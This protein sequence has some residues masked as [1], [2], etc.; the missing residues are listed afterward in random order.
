MDTR[1]QAI[2]YTKPGCKLCEE[3][4]EAMSQS[5]CAEL[6]SLEEVDI[7]SDAELF[8][9]YQYEIPI[10]FIN[11]VEA[12]RHRLRADEFKEYVTSLVDARP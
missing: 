6:Y 10:L 5:G 8:A 9:R 4:K 11:G 7:E 2:L 12:F 3:M 1:V